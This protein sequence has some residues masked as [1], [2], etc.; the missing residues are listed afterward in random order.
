[1]E[2]VYHSIVTEFF[3]DIYQNHKNL[4]SCLDPPIFFESRKLEAIYKDFL[5]V[6]IVQ[7]D[8]S[9]SD[10]PFEGGRSMLLFIKWKNGEYKKECG[11]RIRSKAPFLL[12]CLFSIL[13][14]QS[15]TSWQL[16][17][18]NIFKWPKSIFTELTKTVNLDLRSN[19]WLL[20][21]SI[22][23]TTWILYTPFY[24]HF[25]CRLMTV[26]LYFYPTRYS[27]SNKRRSFTFSPEWTDEQSQE[28]LYSS[29]A[30]LITS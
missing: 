22:F 17:E 20:E 24:T 26:Q 4:A 28:S 7:F 3:S 16:S 18:G 30:I 21:Q 2:G 1:M 11:N 5:S 19:N 12:H 14:E 13:Y 9:I 29:L 10:C 23:L 25:N 8:P 15:L 6:I 27:Y